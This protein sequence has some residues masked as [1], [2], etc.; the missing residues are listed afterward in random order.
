MENNPNEFTLVEEVE[1]T[2]FEG[3]A[4]IL[5]VGKLIELLH[6]HDLN[7]PVGFTNW[8]DGECH[9]IT[10]LEIRQVEPDG[11]ILTR[12]MEGASPK[13]LVLW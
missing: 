8:E 6:A 2:P 4:D 1:A 13:V 3:W 12:D 11:G 7:T 9:F 5:T 10:G